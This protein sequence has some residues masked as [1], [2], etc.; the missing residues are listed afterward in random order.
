MTVFSQEEDRVGQLIAKEPLVEECGLDVRV[1]FVE[2]STSEKETVGAV[3][4][5]R[6]VRRKRA[7]RVSEGWCGITSSEEWMDC[8][9]SRLPLPHLLILEEVCVKLVETLDKALYV[10]LRHGSINLRGE[11]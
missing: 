6:A 2:R 4:N 7:T 9:D 1:I 8:R 10:K 5:S 3:P 11:R